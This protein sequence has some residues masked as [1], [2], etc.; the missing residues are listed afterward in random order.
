MQSYIFDAVRTPRGKA[1]PDGALADV[2]PQELVRQLIE[3]IDDRVG[4][5]VHRVDAL[6]LGCVGQVG[7]QGGNVALLAK[8]HSGLAASTSATSVNNYCVSGLSAIGHACANIC[9]GQAELVLAGGVEHMSRV[10]FMAD[11]ASYYG[12][13]ALP[14]RARYLPVAVAADRMAGVWNITRDD[15]DARAAVSQARAAAADASATGARSRIAIRDHHGTVLLDRDENVRAV[16]AGKLRSLTPAFGEMAQ[17]FAY[18]LDGEV[19]TPAHTVAHAPPMSDAAALALVGAAGAIEAEP[20]ARVVAFAEVGGDAFDG[21]TAG[22]AAMERALSLAKLTLADMDRIEFMEAFGATI[23]RFLRDYPVDP[24]K[25]NVVG[26]H[27]ARGHPLGASGA[28]LLSTLLDVLDECEGRYG[29]VVAMGASGAGAAMIV[30]R[31]S[32]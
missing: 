5:E 15:L 12:D 27:L 30:E 9:A 23:A 17:T 28:I 24:D 1:R 11:K 8:L 31:G 20:R 14:P 19:V 22:F 16:E 29:L 6:I 25:V 21:L 26:G 3:A 10:P 2:P 18:A 32:V 13:T 4:G 7:A